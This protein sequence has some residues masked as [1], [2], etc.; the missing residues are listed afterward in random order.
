MEAAKPKQ[1]AK[2]TTTMAVVDIMNFEGKN[3][4]QIDLPDAVFG[5]R[6]N[7][8]LQGRMY[9]GRIRRYALAKGRESDHL[10]SLLASRRFRS[11]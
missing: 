8:T 7:P 4:G 11:A 1:Q 3:V 2:D 9:T 10:R 5:A 6:V